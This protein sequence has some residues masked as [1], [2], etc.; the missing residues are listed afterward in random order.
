MKNITIFTL[1]TLRVFAK[2]FVLFT[3]LLYTMQY[4]FNSFSS[5]NIIE[6]SFGTSI[7][8]ALFFSFFLMKKL[9]IQEN[10]SRGAY[11]QSIKLNKNKEEIVNLIKNIL[12]KSYIQEFDNSIKI[13]KYD[14]F[15]SYGEM[16]FITF[17][18]D[19]ML[20]TTSSIIPNFADSKILNK[21][22]K[23]IESLAS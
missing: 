5:R 12:N 19:N 14:Y 7:F 13:F 20:V 9:S 22:L 2:H 23:L 11:M 18:N 17:E 15:N 16:I 3:F 8:L 1:M 4:L 10:K 6:I 21:N